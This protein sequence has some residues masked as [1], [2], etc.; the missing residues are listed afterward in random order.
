MKNLIFTTIISS[1]VFCHVALAQSSVFSMPTTEIQEKDGMSVS[2]ITKFKTNT[3][4][5][6]SQFSSF[7]PKVVFG[8]AKD[9][10]FGFSLGGNVQ[11]GKD[12]TTLTPTLK[13]RFYKNEK[14]GVEMVAGNNFYI[15]VHNKKYNFGTYT[16][17]AASKTVKATKTKLTFGGYLYS[18]DVVATNAT[19]SGGQFGVEQYINKRMKFAAE[20]ITGRHSG[21]YFL[22]GFKIKFTK[23]FSTKI[24]YL[25]GNKNA[26]KGNHYF[27][28]STGY[29]FNY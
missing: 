17:V 18:K 19:R 28:F 24:G 3:E 5:A 21:G 10:E 9:V 2:L 4:S 16:Y 15:P 22:P 26:S 14:Q 27:Y 7:T 29:D 8:V 20:Y 6:K 25:I 23:A 13:W 12:T 11:P 1:V